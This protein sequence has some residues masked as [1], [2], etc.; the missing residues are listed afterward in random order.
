MVEPAFITQPNG[1]DKARFIG[2]REDIVMDVIQKLSVE[3]GYFFN[4]GGPNDATDN[5]VLQTSLYAISQELKRRG[6]EKGRS[7]NTG[8]KVIH[9]S[10]GIRPVASAQK[11]ASQTPSV[12][13]NERMAGDV[14]CGSLQTG[15]VGV[16]S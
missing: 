16:S 1:E 3:Q 9:R 8:A 2:L 12:Q 4:D 14:W 13:R 7:E 10:G 5:F 15:S 11:C 6:K